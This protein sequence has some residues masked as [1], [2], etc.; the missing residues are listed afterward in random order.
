MLST[1]QQQNWDSSW[2]GIPRIKSTA[3]CDQ[4]LKL[5]SSAC[6]NYEF[7]N[8]INCDQVLNKL[9]SRLSHALRQERKS[10]KAP[11]E[12]QLKLSIAPIHFQQ[13]YLWPIRS[14]TISIAAMKQWS[15]S[16][17]GSHWF[18]LPLFYNSCLLD[19]KLYKEESN[20]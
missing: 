7:T 6:K 8:S 13:H 12:N 5:D 3:W 16:R 15:G 11:R 1:L 19:S 4:F 2:F 14:I 10:H 9:W 20:R 18:N 17:N